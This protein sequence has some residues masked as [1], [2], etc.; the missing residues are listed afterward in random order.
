MSNPVFMAVVFEGERKE[1]CSLYGKMKRLQERKQSLVENGFYYPKRWLGNL[2]VRLGADWHDVYCRGTWSDL[3]LSGNVVRFFTETAWQ[4][5]FALLQLVRKCY[6]S[7]EYY[8]AAEGDDWDSYL[9][10]DAEGRFFTSRY[11]VDCEPDIEY[12]D[13][14]CEACAYLSSFLGKPVAATWDALY[15]AAEQWNDKHEDAD[16]PVC[17]KQ[18]EVVTDDEL[19]E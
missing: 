14:I 1:V 7:L 3:Q 6:P 10:N 15:A 18:Y 4:P 2:V 16:W 13:T 11:M 9:T 8:L 12:F 19:W 5:P 17:V